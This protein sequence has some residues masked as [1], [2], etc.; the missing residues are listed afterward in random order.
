MIY[1]I[2]ISLRTSS[3]RMEIKSLSGETN[4]IINAPA[5]IIIKDRI[6]IL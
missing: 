3:V 1:A 5:I 4:M 2:P 6:M